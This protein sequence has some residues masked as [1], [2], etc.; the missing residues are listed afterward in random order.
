MSEFA[1]EGFIADGDCDG[2]SLAAI[3]S[4]GYSR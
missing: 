2:D 4:L 1:E 3:V